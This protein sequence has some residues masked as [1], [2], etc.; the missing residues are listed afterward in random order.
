MKRRKFVLPLAVVGI[1]CVAVVTACSF[2]DLWPYSKAG[3]ASASKDPITIV[4]NSLGLGFPPGLDEN[5]NPYLDYI[6]NNTNTNVNVILPPLEGYKEKLNLFM[7]MDNKPDMLNVF[8]DVWVASYVNQN[9]LLPLDD[10]LDKYGPD[11]KAQMPKEA[12]DKV[13]FNGK[14]YA[15]P[16]VN[17]VKGVEL[18]YARKDWLDRLGL[19]PPK[20]LDEYYTVIKAFKERDPDGNGKD[21]TIGLLMTEYLGR[22]APFFGAFGVQL[23]QWTE[24]NGKLV[25]TNILPQT[26]GALGFLSRLYSEGLLDPEFPLNKTRNLEEK[27][28]SGK[29]GIYSATWYDTRGPI[30]LNK[31]LDPNAEWIP[32]E[33]P[34]GPNGEKG[35]Y[36]SP[37]VREYEVIP[38]GSKN[39]EAVIRMLN[40]I[41]GDGYSN[42]KLG[43]EN[44]IWSWQN[45]KIVTN[46][47]EHNKHQYRGIYHSL[48]EVGRPDL[49]KV[50]LDSLGDFHL[51][52]NQQLIE[53]NLI[54]NQFV[55]LP[56]PAME[57]YKAKL[58]S[59]QD[60]F[61][62]IIVGTEPLDEFDR[63]VER[64]KQ[65]GGDEMTREVNEWFRAA[66]K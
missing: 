29:V 57:K 30:A 9:A 38:V 4:V 41:A 13:T 62:K 63:Y 28:K 42:L 54:K 18:M 24:Q 23:N 47:A 26:K 12:W 5:N 6:E 51:Y 14:I 20:T 52:E 50:R 16:S 8:D 27:V 36:D 44:E 35:V 37:P 21:D 15:I 32:L 7:S 25:N 65:E 59:L 33:Y 56:T 55:G 19:K 1:S 61:T 43:F 60:V 3:G 46:F 31:D 53:Q 64:W 2:R 10:L 58:T 11:I 48:V 40:F 49:I 17:E 45:G 66:K 34:T 39:P 22:S